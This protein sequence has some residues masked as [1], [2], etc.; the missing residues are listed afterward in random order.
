[1]VLFETG[2]VALH[3][4]LTRSGLLPDDANV[5]ARAIAWI[6]SAL[7]TIEPPI[8]DLSIAKVVDNDQPWA[9][10]RLPLVQDRIRKTLGA[11]SCHLG[12]SD[13]LARSARAI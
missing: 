4:A 1:M 13:W 2:A 10:Q 11:L 5:R 8:L 3:I 7:N 6:F 9:A 12:T